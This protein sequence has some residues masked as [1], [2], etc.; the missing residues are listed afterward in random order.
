M[1]WP[2]ILTPDW[3]SNRKARSINAVL[4]DFAALRGTAAGIRITP[5]TA[6]RCATVF[7]I[8][9]TL[10]MALSRLPIH[11]FRKVDERTRERLDDH[12]VARLFR[13]PNG[14]Q[15]KTEY[16]ACKVNNIL[17][18]GNHYSF[19][20]AGNS[21]IVRQLTPLQPAAV[22]VFQND[23][24]ELT[25]K[26]RMSGTIK[27]FSQ[28]EIHH[29]RFPI[30][31]NGY[32][33]ES[34]VFLAAESIALCMAAEEFGATFFAS[35][36]VPYSVITRPGHFDPE[37]WKR[38]RESWVE[39]ASRKGQRGPMILEDDW[40]FEAVKLNAKEAQ[41]IEVRRFQKQEIAGVFGVPPHKIGDLERATFSNIEHQAL[42]FVQDS[43]MWYVEAFEDAIERDLLTDEDRRNDVFVK[44]N[45]DALLRGDFKSRQTG[46]KIQRDSGIINA[47]EWRKLEDM[48]PRE[49][50]GGDE[51]LTPMNMAESGDTGDNDD[52][53]TA[54]EPTE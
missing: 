7:A 23:D 45:V 52:D 25:Y 39:A 1:K 36:G 11:V 8:V 16:M 46:L 3:L 34:P 27:D 5:S 37:A 30:S 9:R 31:S 35:S 41:V 18:W 42:E 6:L 48:N 22:D 43:L 53:D 15:T 20:A 51:Y 50:E 38:F 47:N 33:G 13:R 44:F 54:A 28:D 32:T 49:D 17:L 21:G 24:L 19:K 29:V 4:E 40:K 10:T 26:V 12:P 14:W 2:K